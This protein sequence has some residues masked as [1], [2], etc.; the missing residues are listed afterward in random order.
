[1]DYIIDDIA[2][3]TTEK[4]SNNLETLVAY[5]DLVGILKVARIE[6]GISQSKLAHDLG[7]TQDK[8]SN[9]ES[10]KVSPRL[11]LFVR[12]LDALGYTIKIVKKGE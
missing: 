1:M 4:K 9:Y 12:Y 2:V 6:K 11:D 10:G 7:I 3:V 5:N 8:I